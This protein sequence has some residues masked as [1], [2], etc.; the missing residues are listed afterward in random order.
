MSNPV[1]EYLRFRTEDDE[2]AALDQLA[3]TSGSCGRPGSTSR[4]RGDATAS[5]VIIV[6]VYRYDRPQS[7][8]RSGSDL[9]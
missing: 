4:S 5:I 6:T 2:I 1:D 9:Q 7:G 3:T 8:G